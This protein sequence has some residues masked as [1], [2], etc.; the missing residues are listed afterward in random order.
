M[1]TAVYQVRDDSEARKRFRENL[2]AMDPGLSDGLV[3]DAELVFDEVY[4]NCRKHGGGSELTV[5]FVMTGDHLVLTFS[6]ES[7]RTHKDEIECAIR[8]GKDRVGVP[9]LNPGGRAYVIFAGLS[10]ECSIDNQGK[11]TISF[12][13]TAAAAA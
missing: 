2:Q 6:A 11:L 7:H 4:Q 13:L 12:P 5:S 10:D 3:D 1:A 9:D 8:Q